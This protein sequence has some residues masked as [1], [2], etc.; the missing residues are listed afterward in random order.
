[1]IVFRNST[2]NVI[3]FASREKAQSYFPQNSTSLSIYFYNFISGGLIGAMI[4]TI[5]YPVNI[6]KARMQTQLGGPFLQP[7]HVFTLIYNERGQQ[8]KELFRGIHLNYTRSIL[9]WG[10]INATYELCKYFLQSDSTS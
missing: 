4:S 3:F 2:A 5:F 9:S 1:M 10:I 8:A 6:V 7:H